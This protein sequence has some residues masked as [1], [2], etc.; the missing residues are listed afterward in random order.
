MSQEWN[1]DLTAAAKMAMALAECPPEQR[2]ETLA[3]VVKLFLEH[4]GVIATL[5]KES[6]RCG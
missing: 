4:P 2:L 1:H 3:F 6:E 5:R